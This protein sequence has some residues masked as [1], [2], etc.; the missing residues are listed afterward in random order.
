MLKG[1]LACR[2]L[3]SAPLD[4]CRDLCFQY[5]LTPEDHKLQCQDGDEK[6]GIGW[7]YILLFQRQTPADFQPLP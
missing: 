5:S 6:Q 2:S 3:Y 4:G 1:P 7:T